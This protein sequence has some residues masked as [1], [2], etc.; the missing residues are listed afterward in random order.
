MIQ[1]SKLDS[2]MSP[3]S[4]LGVLFKR[5]KLV[6]VL[7]SVI[8]ASIVGSTFLMPKVYKASTQVYIRYLPSLSGTYLAENMSPQTVKVDYELLET[9]VQFVH[10]WN[11]VRTVVK[12]FGLD[13]PEDIQELDENSIM[14]YQDKVV[15]EFGK[16]L[17]VEREKDTNILTISFEDE[18]PRFAANVVDK[19]AE[20]YMR[21]RP[22]WDRDERAYKFFDDELKQ[23]EQRID[24]IELASKS[25]KR[26]SNVLIP[27]EQTEILFN[28]LANFDEELTNVRADRI[29]KEA[30]LQSIMR[31][32]EHGDELYVPITESTE[33]LAKEDYMNHMR[34]SLMDK[35]VQKEALETKYT[36]QHPEVQQTVREIAELE[37]RIKLEIADVVRSEQMMVETLKAQEAALAQSME[38]VVSDINDLATEEYNIKKATM[39]LED[40]QHVKSTLVRQRE[41]ARI[42]GNRGEY[43]T[44]IR[45][46]QS[47]MVPFVP[48]KPNKPLYAALALLL[49]T[50]VS[51]GFAFFLEYFD[52]SVNT[53]EDAQNCL[54]LPILAQI[55]DFRVNQA[56]ENNGNTSKENRKKLF[57]DVLT[58]QN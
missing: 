7:F 24:A 48:E 22:D 21:Q 3:H 33:S 37:K 40:L 46:V 57:D 28:K 45:L 44:Q 2:P 26:R 20:E 54:G 52:H 39:S 53:A 30:R 56:N 14:N 51:I 35:K 36:D 13:K 5:R 32:M 1:Y 47:A 17:K 16:K 55:K 9:E 43:T 41:E 6:L 4:F 31:A 19:I 42:A 29:S 11:I 25:I 8:V 50:V 10:N 38:G 34:K 12:H 27:A 15:Y 58:T 23:I 49:G 18:N